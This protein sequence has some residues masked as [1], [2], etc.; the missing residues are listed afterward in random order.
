MKQTIARANKKA[1]G[2]C[3]M[4]RTVQAGNQLC[5]GCVRV[6][7]PRMQREQGNRLQNAAAT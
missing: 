1:G 6:L 7:W 4:R 3:G 2:P 5:N